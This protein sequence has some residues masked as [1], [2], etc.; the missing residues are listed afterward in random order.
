MSQEEI[1]TNEEDVAVIVIIRSDDEPTA[2]FSTLSD[3][4]TAKRLRLQ[5]SPTSYNPL[6][7]LKDSRS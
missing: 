3:L 1:A 2:T 7:T 6:Y 4:T 5:L